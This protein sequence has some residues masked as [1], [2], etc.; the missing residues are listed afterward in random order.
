MHVT[1]HAKGT[2]RWRNW[3]FDR[4]FGRSVKREAL[5]LCSQRRLACSTHVTLAF[6]EEKILLP[7]T[8]AGQTQL[9]AYHIRVGTCSTAT[10]PRALGLHMLHRSVR[11]MSPITGAGTF[12]P[13]PH[14]QHTYKQLDR[15]PSRAEIC[16]GDS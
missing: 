2:V 10:V 3:V 12:T 15:N 1:L 8:K 14:L 7:R 4:T 13:V 16:I 6:F 9:T 5:R 11:W